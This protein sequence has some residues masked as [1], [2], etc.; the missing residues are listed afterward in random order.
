MDETTDDCFQSVVNTLFAFY[1]YTKLISVDFLECGD[2]KVDCI[3]LQNTNYNI[4]LQ[5]TLYNAPLI[6]AFSS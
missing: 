4:V 6:S 2:L 5:S 3:V 1:Q